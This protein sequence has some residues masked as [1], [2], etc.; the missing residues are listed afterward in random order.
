MHLHIYSILNKC[1]KAALTHIL[2]VGSEV[3]NNCATVTVNLI[4]SC[5]TLVKKGITFRNDPT[6][7]YIL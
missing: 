5:I 6:F 2:H 4:V 1:I 7:Y 3:S